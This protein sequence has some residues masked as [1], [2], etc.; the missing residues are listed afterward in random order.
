MKAV[1]KLRTQYRPKGSGARRRIFTLT[2]RDLH[3]LR[4]IAGVFH[5]EGRREPSASLLIGAGLQLLRTYAAENG[6]PLGWMET[7]RSRTQ[8]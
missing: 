6:A 1:E 4:E 2:R 5:L 8:V 7:H 3:N